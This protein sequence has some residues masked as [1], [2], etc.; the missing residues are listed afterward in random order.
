[1]LHLVFYFPQSSPS[2]FEPRPSTEQAL[3]FSLY[4]NH[5][6]IAAVLCAELIK[7]MNA[8]SSLMVLKCVY[9]LDCVCVHDRIANPII[10]DG[11]H[12][13]Q[14]FSERRG[15]EEGKLGAHLD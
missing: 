4:R 12:D 13:K 9:N 14:S 6:F 10:L 3:P 1:M 11:D 2:H 5:F 7:P 15:E 8:R